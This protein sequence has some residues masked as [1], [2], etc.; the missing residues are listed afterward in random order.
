MKK[1]I[2]GALLLAGVGFAVYEYYTS[3]FFDAPELQEGDFLLAFKGE[4]SLKGVMH[5]IDDERSQ[6]RYLAYEARD[7]PTWYRDTWSF[8]RKPSEGE[9]SSFLS[10]VDVGP[11]GRL[12]AVCEINADGDVF[13]RGWIASV[14]DL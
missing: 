7:V 9:L 6:R 5:G 14:P 2:V 1:K 11:G 10:G 3:P 4:G 8:C 13:V 12:D